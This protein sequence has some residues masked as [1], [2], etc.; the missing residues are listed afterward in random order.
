MQYPLFSMCRYF[1]V[2]VADADTTSVVAVETLGTMS[3]FVDS[4]ALPMAPRIE[5]DAS[6]TP[7]NPLTPFS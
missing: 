7:F 6:V 2:V 5:I 1:V 4:F 3:V